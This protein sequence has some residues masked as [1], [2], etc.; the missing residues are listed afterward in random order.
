MGKG[1][2]EEAVFLCVVKEPVSLRSG[3]TSFQAQGAVGA[4]ALG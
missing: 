1:L 2:S 3:G 4:K